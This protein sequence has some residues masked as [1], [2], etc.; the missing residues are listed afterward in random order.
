MN[1]GALE[2]VVIQ[3]MIKD[4]AKT[5]KENNDVTVVTTL[6]TAGKIIA[7]LEKFEG[8]F[9]N[10]CEDVEDFTPVIITRGKNYLCLEELLFED[11][12]CKELEYGS[13]TVYVDYNIKFV[14]SER[15]YDGIVSSGAMTV[16]FL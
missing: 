12:I 16:N 11:N 4:M 3:T 8:H 13:T 5:V 1:I 10:Y 7:H 14:A 2:K 15:I 9:V 6:G